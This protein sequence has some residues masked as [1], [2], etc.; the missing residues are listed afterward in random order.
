MTE[1]REEINDDE[2]DLPASDPNV[3]AADHGEGGVVNHEDHLG[4]FVE[5]DAPGGAQ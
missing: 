3:A 1:Y 4:E 2:T 5:D